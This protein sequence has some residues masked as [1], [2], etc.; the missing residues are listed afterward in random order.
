MPSMSIFADANGKI[1]FLFM[2]K[3]Y[4][5]IYILIHMCIYIYG[6]CIY[7]CVCMY[8]Y[9][10]IYHNFIHLFL[11]GHLG[12]FPL[13]TIINNSTMNTEV[14]VS[15]W[16]S[17]LGV[18]PDI[19]KGLE[20]LGHM[21]VLYWVFWDASI[22]FSTVAAPIYIS[23]NKQCTRIFFSPHPHQHLLFLFFSMTVIC[24]VWGDISLWLWF[25]FPW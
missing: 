15:F 11:D 16:I 14:H 2:A 25:A 8:I 24:Q 12:F 18:F 9:T 5:I 13:L 10:Y 1:S 6:M 7:M 19:Y 3:Q 20:L 17:V 21:V 23:T 4:S 22:I